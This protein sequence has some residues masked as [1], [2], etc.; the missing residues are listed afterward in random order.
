[1]A[2]ELFCASF[3]IGM[4]LLII[5]RSTVNRGWFMVLQVSL[6]MTFAKGVLMKQGY[7]YCLILSLMLAHHVP[8]HSHF[9]LDMGA[10][11]YQNV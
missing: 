5:F 11:A 7:C 6:L 9:G 3:T 10:R 1:M 2:C 8:L 4:V